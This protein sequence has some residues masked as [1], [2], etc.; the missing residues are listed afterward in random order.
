M[1]IWI[2]YSKSRSVCEEPCSKGIQPDIRALTTL[3]TTLTCVNFELGNY[4]H[5]AFLHNISSLFWLICNLYFCGFDCYFSCFFSLFPP[6]SLFLSLF[7][8]CHCAWSWIWMDH[9]IPTHAIYFSTISSYCFFFFLP[10]QSRCM[11]F[12]IFDMLRVC[13]CAFS[14]TWQLLSDVHLLADGVLAVPAVIAVIVLWARGVF[15]FMASWLDLLL[16]IWSFCWYN[17]AWSVD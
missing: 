16:M 14:H 17:W 13:V 1:M 7:V 11:N 12:C 15:V 3:F 6:I 10:M 8:V 2:T 5:S 4:F 9:H